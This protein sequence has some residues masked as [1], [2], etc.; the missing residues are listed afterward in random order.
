MFTVEHMPEDTIITTLDQ[1]GKCND[2]EVIIDAESVFFR[3]WSDDME[4]YDLIEMSNQQL[5]DIVAAMNSPEGAYYA[6]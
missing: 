1:E 4:V 5:K 6:D 2:V 3:Q